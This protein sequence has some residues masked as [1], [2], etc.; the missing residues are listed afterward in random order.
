MMLPFSYQIKRTKKAA[1]A[2][3]VVT[4]DKIEVVAPVNISDDMLHKFVMEQW[5]W[6]INA[7]EKLKARTAHH[8][9]IAPKTYGH[10]S[11]IP[12]QGKTYPLTLAPTKLKRIKID[13]SDVFTVHNPHTLRD[14]VTSDHIRSAIIRWMKLNIRLTVERLVSQ[15]GPKHQLFPRSISIK[16]QKSRWG[17]CGIH[18]DIA[19]NWL[20]AL[21]PIEILEYVVVHEL[22]HIKEKN[23][24]QQFWAL[25][26]HHLPDYRQ[27]RKWLKQ[28]GSTLMLGL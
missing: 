10:G 5:Q 21:A 1:K 16:Q 28:Q 20:L 11:I 19:I 14:T 2:R 13:H 17:S 24:S 9:S 4:P 22:C 15:H 8:R 25:V 12:Y 3:I 26:G 23:H 27:S 6:I 18:N 7:V